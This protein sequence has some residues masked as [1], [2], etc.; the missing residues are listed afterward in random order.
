MHP[1][2]RAL[3]WAGPSLLA[4]GA[5][6]TALLLLENRGG[7]EILTR[8]ALVG[9]LGF[10]RLLPLAGLGV[11]LSFL[12][13]PSFLASL[14][15]FAAGALAGWE[16]Q[17]VFLALMAPVP[18]AAEHLFLTGPIAA[19]GTGLLLLLP[20]RL[21]AVVTPGF[22]ALAGFLHMVAMRLTDPTLHDPRV[23]PIGFC[24]ALWALLAVSL[25]ARA[26]HPRWL[27]IGSRIL[28]SWLLAIGVLYGAA[29]IAPRRALPVAPP[30]APP[31]LAAAPRPNPLA[32]PAA[33]ELFPRTPTRAMPFGEGASP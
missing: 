21:G 27:R 3:R 22:A 13:R 19:V 4:L 31:P 12:G 7:G 24:A 11:A 23:A 20:R 30:P 15:L 28:G 14:A 33:D 9:P 29:S 1:P 18:H 17:A 8:W 16:G 26:F 10:E 32:G 6:G 5:A 2:E 25:T